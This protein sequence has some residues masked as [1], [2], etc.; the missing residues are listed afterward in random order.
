MERRAPASGA[1]SPAPAP[2][3]LPARDAESGA[4]VG[5]SAMMKSPNTNKGSPA[6]VPDHI[7]QEASPSDKPCQSRSD[8]HRP[9]HGSDRRDRRQAARP[10]SPMRRLRSSVLSPARSGGETS[11]LAATLPVWIR[12]AAALPRVPGR[13]QALHAASQHQRGPNFGFPVEAATPL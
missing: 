9:I 1:E 4:R 2:G 7:L 13:V 11:F 8:Q 5:V 6:R 10:R 3:S 12:R